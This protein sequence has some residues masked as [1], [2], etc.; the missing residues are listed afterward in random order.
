[1]SSLQDKIYE[2]L[3]YYLQNLA[4]SSYGWKIKKERFCDRYFQWQRFLEESQYYSTNELEEYQ[5]EQLRK[6]IAHVYEYVPYYRRIFEEKKLIPSDIKK[7]EDLQK[8]PILTKDDVRINFNGLISTRHKR[9][10]LKEAHS[11]GTTGSPIEI[12]WDQNVDILHNTSIWRHRKWAG[13][14]FG[15]KYATLLGRVIVPLKQNYPPFHRINKAWNQYLFSS[16]HLIDEN[17]QYYFDEFER[18]TIRYMEAYPSTAF[19]LAKYLEQH[20]LYY[21]MKTI[22]TSSETLLPI[23]REVIE[24]RFKCKIFDYYGLA[25]RAMFSGECEVHNGHHLYMEYGITEIL[26]E[27]YN[28]VPNGK[29]GKLILTGL[30]NYGMPLIRYEIGD[31]SAFKNVNCSCNRKLPLLES[32]TTKAEDIVVSTD[33]RLISS[34]VLTHPFKPMNNIIKS[35][36]IQ[37]D[38]DRLL[39][40]IVRRPGY[41]DRDTERLLYAIQ[42]RVGPEMNISVKFVSDIPRNANGKYR[43][44]ISKIPL[45]FDNKEIHNLYAD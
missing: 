25:E 37:E 27:S 39:I 20:N 11:S 7:K 13:F 24:E 21:E 9:N 36:I 42:Q 23:Q 32:V 18:N 10:Q 30:H 8:L 35:Q 1:M 15:E 6:L 34:S 2:Y 4:I 16:F 19:V 29:H 38:Y 12:L 33:G 40:K 5:N 45:R 41:S 22:V 14:E 17:L 43:W 3:P 28:V 26:D 44:V 31:V